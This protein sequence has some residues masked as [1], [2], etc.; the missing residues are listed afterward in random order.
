MFKSTGTFAEMLAQYEAARLDVEVSFSLIFEGDDNDNAE[1]ADAVQ[2]AFNAKVALWHEVA[3]ALAN[4]PATNL[5]EM[6][7][8]VR[9]MHEFEWHLKPENEGKAYVEILA[10]L[11]RLLEQSGSAGVGL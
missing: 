11:E 3:T 7:A 2:E 5:E 6:L 4:T 10:D 1:I 9:F 8:K